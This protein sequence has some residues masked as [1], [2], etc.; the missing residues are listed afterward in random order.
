MTTVPIEPDPDKLIEA[1]MGRKVI[2]KHKKSGIEFDGVVENVM[3][4]PGMIA[5]TVHCPKLDC[6]VNVLDADY[7]VQIYGDTINNA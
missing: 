4:Y 1:M 5:F 7:D 6:T 3:V 2:A